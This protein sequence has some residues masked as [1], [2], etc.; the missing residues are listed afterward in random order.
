[1]RSTALTLGALGHAM[2]AIFITVFLSY[3]NS[4]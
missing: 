1:M 4:K 2:A 3:F